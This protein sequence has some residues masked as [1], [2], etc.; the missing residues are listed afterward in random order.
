MCCGEERIRD[1]AFFWR[2][3]VTCIRPLTECTIDGYSSSQRA[4]PT[5][6]IDNALFKCIFFVHKYIFE[7]MHWCVEICFFGCYSVSYRG[8]AD[9]GI[10]SNLQCL[11]KCCIGSVLE[12]QGGKISCV[13]ARHSKKFNYK[14]LVKSKESHDLD[15]SHPLASGSAQLRTITYFTIAHRLTFIGTLLL[16]FSKLLNSLHN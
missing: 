9:Q 10:V 15:R 1:A 14:L 8:K 11:C 3:G 13:S 4:K 5:V 6:F 12:V 2:P 7:F 16:F